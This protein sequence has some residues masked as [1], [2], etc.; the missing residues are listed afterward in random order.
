ITITHLSDILRAELLYRYG[1][2]YIDATYLVRK[3][4]PVEWFQRDCFYTQR[5]S[6][7]KAEYVSQGKWSQNLVRATAGN[8]LSRYL[9]NAFYISWSA[10]EELIDYYLIDLVTEEAFRSVPVIRKMIEDVPPS[11]PQ[12]MELMP[13][14]NAAYDKQKD[15]ILL[16]D[17]A[18]FKLSYKEFFSGQT[19]DGQSTFYGRLRD[20]FCVDAGTPD[21]SEACEQKKISVIIP[22]YNAEVY[23]GEC[24]DSIFAQTYPQEA[25]EVI[26]VNDASTDATGDVLKRYEAQHVEQMMLVECAANMGQGHARNLGLE[27][28][29]GFYITFVDADDRIPPEYLSILEKKAEEHECEVVRCGYRMYNDDGTTS[30]LCMPEEV[31]HGLLRSPV[32]NQF[33]LTQG[34]KFGNAA[35]GNLFRTD[36]IRKYDLYFPEGVRMEDV[37]F[38]EN[39]LL[40]VDSCCT[41]DQTRYEYRSHFGSIMLSENLK[42]YYM[43]AFYV[44]DAVYEKLLGEGLLQGLQTEMAFIYY[45]KG[46]VIPMEYLIYGDP[47]IPFSEENV[48]MLRDTVMKKFPDIRNN[49]HVRMISTGDREQILRILDDPQTAVHL[50]AQCSS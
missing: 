23:L 26:A 21:V 49:P 28:A 36:F 10:Q 20:E 42:D 32:R 15:D 38:H 4:L 29:T 40:R 8:L 34:Y 9:R 11:Q 19:E 41:T 44:Q 24:L 48:L 6:E 16:Q 3:T 30:D 45:Y 33:I 37:F 18:W 7:S 1:G 43:D 31:Y 50:R 27:Y 46:Y 13:L 22:C 35:W 47:V 17:T 2:L 5:F 14:M 25:I 39:W 12:V